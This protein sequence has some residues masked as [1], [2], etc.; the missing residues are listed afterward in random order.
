M[1]EP[2]I[3]VVMPVYNGAE[4]LREA[5]DSILAQTFEDF[6]FIVIDDGSK[7]FSLE[8]VQQYDDGRLRM[9]MQSNQ[10]LAATLNRGI[11]LAHGKYIARMDQDDI[12][13][14]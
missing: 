3:S 2:V 9:F 8:I 1:T 10:G 6:E 13:M 4:Y 14:S 5:L 12:S 11:E 7:D